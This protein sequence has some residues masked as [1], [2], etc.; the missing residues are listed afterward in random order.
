MG[1]KEKMNTELQQKRQK[2]NDLA[3]VSAA[4]ASSIRSMCSE[5]KETNKQIQAEINETEALIAAYREN[6]HDLES[7]M[8]Y[9]ADIISD[10][11]KIFEGEKEN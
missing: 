2:V 8:N 10:I 4:Y 6:I 1:N 3:G 7:T 9:N 5:L 11:N